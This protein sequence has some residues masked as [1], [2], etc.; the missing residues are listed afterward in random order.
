M[1]I[2]PTKKQSFKDMLRDKRTDLNRTYENTNQSVICDDADATDVDVIPI[3]KEE[4]DWIYLRWQYSVIVKL[5]GKRI[6]YQYFCTRLI[7]LWK[8]TENLILIDLGEDFYIAKFSKIEN[9]NKTLH[10]GP[11]F[12]VGKFL[13]VKQWEPNFAPQNSTPTHTTIWARLP[14]L[15]IEFYDQSILEKIGRKLGALL[16]IDSCTSAKLRGRYARISVQVPLQFPVKK[17]ITVGSHK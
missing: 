12:V 14:N 10:E 11:W 9:K 15:P 1:E 8:P 2:D 17:S 7:D 3:S 13:S 6:G 16:K 4:K 5:V